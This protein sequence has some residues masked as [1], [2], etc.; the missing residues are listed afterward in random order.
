M[1][2]TRRLREI[3]NCNEQKQSSHNPNPRLAKL[4]HW[5]SGQGKDW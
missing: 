3:L 2:T 5:T 1:S 4:R